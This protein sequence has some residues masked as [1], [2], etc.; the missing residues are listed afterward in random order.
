MGRFDVGGSWIP[1]EGSKDEARNVRWAAHMACLISQI[2]VG[3]G[4]RTHCR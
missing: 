1:F 2:C 4:V 3:K